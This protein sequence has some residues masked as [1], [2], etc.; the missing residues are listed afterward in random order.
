[1][2]SKPTSDRPKADSPR[3]LRGLLPFIRPYRGRIALAGVF[4]VLAAITTLLFPAVLGRL[5]DAGLVPKDRNEQLMGLRHHFALLMGVGVAMGLLSATRYYMVTWLG[6]RITADVRSAVYQRVIGHSPGFFET[7][8]TGEVLS[9][10][11]TDTALV[12]TVVGSSL[13]M[14]L[15][16]ALMAVG[17]LVMLI[18]TNPVVMGQVLGVLTLVLVPT[19]VWSR[20]G[21]SLS[22]DS[23]SYTALTSTA[24]PAPACSSPALAVW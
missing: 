18:A 4:L 12:Q 7:T 6:E 13:S 10:L 21:R 23:H 14:G 17:A 2:A 16:N 8:R 9:R 20:R 15:R 5:I 3:A 19:L 24:P 22:R 1:M 11:T